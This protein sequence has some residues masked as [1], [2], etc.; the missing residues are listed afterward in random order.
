MCACTSNMKMPSSS[1]SPSWRRKLSGHVEVH[2]LRKHVA[3][4]DASCSHIV[5]IQG[6]VICLSP[7]SSS[8]CQVPRMLPS[9]YF[10]FYHRF[11]AGSPAWSRSRLG[12]WRSWSPDH[13]FAYITRITASREWMWKGPNKANFMDMW[14]LYIFALRGLPGSVAGVRG[15]LTIFLRT[16]QE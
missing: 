15:V 13:F 11:R 12:C 14:V 1:A 5:R 6:T 4:D 3:E 9:P 16:L 10:D 7:S 2:R 8:F